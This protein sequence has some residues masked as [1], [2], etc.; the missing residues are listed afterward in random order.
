MLVGKRFLSE[1]ENDGIA[2]K[3]LL[4]FTKTTLKVYN[5]DGT[6]REEMP[7]RL[8]DRSLIV[9]SDKGE[10]HLYLMFIEAKKLSVWSLFE[11][12]RRSGQATWMPIY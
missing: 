1:F 4:V 9:R 10:F 5:V 11:I 12:M 6:L 7:Y 3:E 8:E 2:A